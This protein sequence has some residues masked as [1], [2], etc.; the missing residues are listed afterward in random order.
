M[1]QG[2]SHTSEHRDGI[3]LY[4]TEVEPPVTKEEGMK[5]TVF[6]HVLYKTKQSYIQTELGSNALLVVTVIVNFCR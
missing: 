4:L 1:K 2:I 5:L 6:M 3:R